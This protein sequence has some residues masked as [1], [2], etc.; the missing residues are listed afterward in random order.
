MAVRA[1]RA[2]QVRAPQRASASK[3]RELAERDQPTHDDDGFALSLMGPH[4]VH[5]FHAPVSAAHGELARGQPSPYGWLPT[6]LVG[7]APR[8]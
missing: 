3:L 7:S 1:T 6:G 4:G 8:A 5:A 2:A